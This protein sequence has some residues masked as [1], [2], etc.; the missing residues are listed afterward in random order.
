MVG[1]SLS[2]GLREIS[3]FILGSILIR[4]TYYK[5]EARFSTRED[6]EKEVVA[7]SREHMAGLSY[8]GGYVAASSHTD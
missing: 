8:N 4:L 3:G 5:K 2:P 1:M 6:L 7:D